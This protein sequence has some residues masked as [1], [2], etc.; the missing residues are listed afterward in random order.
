MILLR[1]LNDTGWIQNDFEAITFGVRHLLFIQFRIL[2]S[3]G[4]IDLYS[5]LVAKYFFS[6]F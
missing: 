2:V 5:I 3:V 1:F 6:L 4:P